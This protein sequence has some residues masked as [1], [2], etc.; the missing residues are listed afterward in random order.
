MTG[1]KGAG[2]F[3]DSNIIQ[4][5]TEFPSKNEPDPI[6]VNANQSHRCIM[7]RSS[8][9]LRRSQRGGGTEPYEDVSNSGAPRVRTSRWL[10]RGIIVVLSI[11][12][13]AIAVVFGMSASTDSSL[14]TDA[15]ARRFPAACELATADIGEADEAKIRRICSHCHQLPAPDILPRAAWKSTVWQ[16]FQ[17]A[18]YGT[19]PRWDIAPEAVIDW[20][21]SRASDQLV[22]P[23]IREPTI[24]PTTAALVKRGTTLHS[25]GGDAS[26][27]HILIADLDEN[28]SPELVV[29]DM[30]N[31]QVLMRRSSDAT[32]Q[33]EPI[34]AVPVPAH[35]EV[36][37]FDSDGRADLV[38]ANLGSY[39]ALDHN[40]GSVEW[41]RQLED[42]TFQRTTLWDGLGRVADVQPDD[43]DRDGDMDL[44]VA[45][46]GWHQTG[47]VLFLENRTSSGGE[48]T[49]AAHQV[50]G[51]HGASHVRVVDLDDDGRREI[52][53]LYSQGYEMVRC[54]VPLDNF[55]FEIRDLYR[56]PSPAWGFTGLKTVDLDGD[57]DLDLLLSN[58]DTFDNNIVKPYHGVQWLENHGAFRFEPHSLATMYG[59]Y[60]ADAADIDADGDLDVVACALISP[61]AQDGGQVPERMDSLIWL[62]QVTPGEFVRHVL[63]SQ[64]THHPTL[65]CGDGDGDGRMD[66][67]VG[68]GQLNFAVAPSQQACIEFWEPTPR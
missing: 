19:A 9:R 25:P 21:E 50:D 2:T 48:V 40:L 53:V 11:G 22:F 34:A 67:L 63:E 17:H 45:D 12:L 46:F 65:T 20:Y 43:F 62:E 52:V 33:L 13:L 36:V 58:G 35:A 42:G 23:V 54:Y 10:R 37:D 60:C 47:Q 8:R 56:A 5:G 39:L 41:L 18:G 15:V 26:V 30:L 66:V 16:M 27:S 49:F 29:C 64:Q 59:A 68:N 55:A 32:G 4:I 44:I 24:D 38:I 51:L 3:F 61:A 1:M 28:A 6:R 57:G 31:G 7:S 14:A